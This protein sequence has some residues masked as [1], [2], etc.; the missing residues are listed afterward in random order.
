MRKY[1]LHEPSFDSLDEA[2]VLETLRSS[3][4]STGGPYV[5]RFEREFAAFVGA[6]HAVSVCNGTIA[7]QLMIEALAL[8]QGVSEKF[9]VIVPTL[10]FIAT[11]N[12]VVHA[13]GKPVFVD[14]A[15]G[16][17]NMSVSAF[18]KILT[19]RYEWQAS[20]KKWTSRLDGSPLL[21]VMP[22][23]IM[24]WTTD[25][26]MLSESCQ[27]H[28]IPLIEDAAE[29]LGSYY[30]D[31]SH[32]GMTGACSAFSFNGNKILTTGGGGM[33]ITN[34][35]ELAARLKH[36][37]TTAKVDG[38]RF[39]HDEVGYNYR[40]V[41]ILAALGCSQLQKLEGRLARKREIFAQYCE[42]LAERPVKIYSQ[43]NCRSNNWLVCAEFEEQAQMEITLQALNKNGI[44]ARPLWTP[45]HRQPAYA[46][47]QNSSET[48]PHAERMWHT[49]LSLPSSPQLDTE[50][51]RF[52]TQQLQ[53]SFERERG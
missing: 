31:G 39:V 45:L 3:W 24:G 42:S 2:C 8:R 19:E 32:V 53:N 18:E 47:F 25:M 10:T 21:A 40:L 23:H 5:D 30:N 43:K 46:Q 27:K 52:I 11:G 36:L 38:L 7:I 15:P 35:P 14:S 33:I 1:A 51:I 29:A 9:D 20:L 28:Q 50:D 22:A 17:L 12:A 34:Q 16:S 6:K 13:G 49:V 4:V 48:F 26:Q 44:E 41:N 37:S